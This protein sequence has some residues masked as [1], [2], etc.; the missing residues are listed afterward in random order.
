MSKILVTGGAGFI[1]SHLVDRLIKDGHEVIVLDSFI[2]GKKENVN[3]KADLH[4]VD[5]SDYEKIT[6]FF[7]DVE[8]VFHCAALARIRPSVLDPLPANRNNITGTLNVL[9]ASKNAGVKKLIYSASSSAYGEQPRENYPLKESLLIHPASPYALQKYVGELYCKLFSELYN[10]PTVILRYFNVYG[11][12]Q[13]TEGAYATVVGVFLKQRLENNPI[14][15][16]GDAGER[17]RDFT[18]VFDVVE[19]NILAWKKDVGGGELFNIG[20]GQNYSINEVAALIGGPTVK[21]DP[22][23]WEY[24][25]TLADNTKARQMLGWEPKISFEEGIAQLKKLHGLA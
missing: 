9:W 5:V 21:I 11:P 20:R 1:G 17:R 16:T 8:V 18:H 12:R 22:R 6:G 19:A 13:L 7:K 10:L 24:P 15:I 3:P 25:L 2:T 14:T 4:E 23:P